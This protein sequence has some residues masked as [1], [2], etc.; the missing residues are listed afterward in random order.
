MAYIFHD[1]ELD[2]VDADDRVVGKV[3][4]TEVNRLGLVNIRSVVAFIKNSHGQLWI[5]RRVKE[6]VTF[7]LGLDMSVAGHVSSGESYDDA[8]ARELKEELRLE[9]DQVMCHTLG[10]ANP[11]EHG[12][13]AFTKVYEICSDVSPNYNKDDFCDSYWLAP[14]VII[15]QIENGE[16]A[17]SDLAVLVKMFY[18]SD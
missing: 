15:E 3:F 2:R 4:R 1:E 10:K 9:L 13:H 12:V 7:P 8:F 6:K 14:K 17:K 11:N 18:I 5:P 16:P